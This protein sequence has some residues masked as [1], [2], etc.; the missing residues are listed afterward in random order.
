MSLLNF[1][2]LPTEKHIWIPMNTCPKY[3][4]ESKNIQSK[5]E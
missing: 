5:S 2:A 3:Q 1:F 4:D